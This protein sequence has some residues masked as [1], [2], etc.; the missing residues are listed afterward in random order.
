[1]KT[2]DPTPRKLLVRHAAL[3]RFLS[4]A[5]HWVK[6]AEAAFNFPNSLN[7]INTCLGRELKDVELIL[8]FDGD[9]PD[10]RIR[11]DAIQ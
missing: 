6:K 10:F 5:G 1:M 9:R 3:N 4:P 11:L 2:N 8:R 7:A